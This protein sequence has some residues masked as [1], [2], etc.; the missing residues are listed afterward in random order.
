MSENKFEYSYDAPTERERRE[1]ESLKKKYAPKVERV[2]KMAELRS[3]DKK[4]QSVPMIWAWCLGVVGTLIFGTGLTMILEWD[5]FSWGAVIAAVGL[6]PVALAYPV[7]KWM[8]Q[9]LSDRYR[10]RILT[11]SE[12]ILHENEE[13]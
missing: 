5:L 2:D 10:E 1:V 4:V 12:E 7:H 13:D 3:L 8:S 11:L 9:R 6:I